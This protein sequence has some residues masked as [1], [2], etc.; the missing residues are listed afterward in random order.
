MS[1]WTSAADQVRW[2][3]GVCVCLFSLLC[4]L[5]IQK[6]CNL[7]RLQQLLTANTHPT[8]NI[9]QSICQTDIYLRFNEHTLEGQKSYSCA[10]QC[11]PLPTSGSATMMIIA[12]KL[13]STRHITQK[14]YISCES[15]AQLLSYCFKAAA[16]NL[17]TNG[18]DC[19]LWEVY[20]LHLNV[21]NK[22]VQSPE[23]C[24][25]FFCVCYF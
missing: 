18:V 3:L 6:H 20:Y 4:F 19:Y 22:H 14:I 10:S 13:D 12:G 2:P 16:K 8:P 9:V 7:P 23:R 15:P 1:L 25:A 17:Y 21:N 5:E 11:R 24:A